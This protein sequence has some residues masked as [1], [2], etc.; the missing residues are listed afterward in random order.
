MV[1]HPPPSC[2][3]VLDTKEQSDST[4]VLVADCIDLSL[5]VGLSEEQPGLRLGRSDDDPTLR[6]S[7]VRGRGRVLNE[8]EPQCVDEELDGVVVVLDD[9]RGLLDVHTP[10]VRGPRFAAE[11]V[12]RW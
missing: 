2:L 10:T 11:C 9:Q 12:I 7:I 1:E 6:T 4:C 5:A 8:V 3:E